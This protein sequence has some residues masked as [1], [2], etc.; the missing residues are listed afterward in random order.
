MHVQK[1]VTTQH[2]ALTTRRPCCTDLQGQAFHVHGYVTLAFES[3]AA[4]LWTSFSQVCQQRLAHL[5]ALDQLGASHA[6][7]VD[8]L[9]A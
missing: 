1:G 5:T 6:L 2:D 7:L 3:V 8:V 9:G 4:A